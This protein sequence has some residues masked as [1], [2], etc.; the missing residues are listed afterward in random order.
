MTETREPFF[1]NKSS[2]IEGLPGSLYA[3]EMD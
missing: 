3:S 2:I 1:Q